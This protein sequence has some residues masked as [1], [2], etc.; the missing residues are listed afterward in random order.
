MYAFV[1]TCQVSLQKIFLTIQFMNDTSLEHIEKCRDKKRK[2][3]NDER[4][5]VK[6]E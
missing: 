2:R 3:E 5:E 4:I 6:L 1:G